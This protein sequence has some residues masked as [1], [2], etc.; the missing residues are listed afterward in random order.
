MKKMAKQQVGAGDLKLKVD[1]NRRW[2]PSI[3]TW[4]TLVLSNE[5]LPISDEIEHS[6][7]A[8]SSHKPGSKSVELGADTSNSHKWVSTC[9]PH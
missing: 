7:A 4:P 3:Y 9:C 8:L 2:Q 1:G 5:L 6:S